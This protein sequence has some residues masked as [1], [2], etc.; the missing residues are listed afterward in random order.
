[1]VRHFVRESPALIIVENWRA[2]MVMSFGLIPV[3]N[4]TWFIWAIRPPPLSSRLTTT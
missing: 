2:K 3:P 1:M 4:L